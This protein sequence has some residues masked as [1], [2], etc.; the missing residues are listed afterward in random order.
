M[1]LDTSVDIAVFLIIVIITMVLLLFKDP[2]RPAIEIFSWLGLFLVTLLT[3][4]WF[5]Q[6]LKLV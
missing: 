2:S 3:L 1:V 6:H 5:A 4:V